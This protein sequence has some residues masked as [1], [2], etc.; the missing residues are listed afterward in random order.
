MK[1]LAVLL[2]TLCLTNVALNLGNTAIASNN[3]EGKASHVDSKFE[4]PHNRWAI[5]RQTIQVHVPKNAQALEKLSID[6]PT[7]VEFLASQ[8]NI[9]DNYNRPV[10]AQAAIQNRR[11]QLDFSTP[12]ASGTYIRINLNHVKRT[13]LAQSPLYFIFGKVVDGAE[14]F[15]GEAYFPL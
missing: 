12:I 11:L 5:V 15:I 13:M 4:F 1:K 9:T 14:N 10:I 3:E 8:V 6:L 7:N 2:A